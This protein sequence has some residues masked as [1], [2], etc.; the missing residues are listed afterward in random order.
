M[1]R[2]LTQSH[3]A[4]AEPTCHCLDLVLRAQEC[5]PNGHTRC[6]S[7]LGVSRCVGVVVHVSV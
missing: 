6:V 1:I 5:M 3:N 7:I 2:Y 4:D